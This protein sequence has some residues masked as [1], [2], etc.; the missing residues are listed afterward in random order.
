MKPRLHIHFSILDQWRYWFSKTTYIPQDGEYLMNHSR[1]GLVM[2]MRAALPHGGRVGVMV[3]NCHTVMNAIAQAGC[4]PV[5]LDINEQMQLSM[6]DSQQEVIKNLNAIIVTHLFGIHNDIEAIR[7]AFPQL[8]IIEDCA[9]AYGMSHS[10]M[11]GDFATFSIGQ[12][13][14]PSIGD[15]G[16]LWVNKAECNRKN[17]DIVRNIESLYAQLPTYSTIQEFKLF[18]RMV[19]MSW[20]HLPIVYT[21]LTKPILKRDKGPG[22]V[23]T[24]EPM[25]RMAK[26]VQRLYDW[27]KNRVPQEIEKQRLSAIQLQQEIDNLPLETHCLIGDNAFMLVVLCNDKQRLQVMIQERGI[28]SATH[29]K[30]CIAWAKQFGY[31]MGACPIAEK[32]TNQLLMIPTYT[33][34]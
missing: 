20:L 25:C 28:E 22:D 33:R 8:I 16:V 29:F 9:H 21:Y 6:S 15:G 31:P 30:Y 27:V 3:Y 18:A 13:K 7:V 32:M 2:A 10:D 1:S 24:I 11:K 34:Q 14:L 17:A 5:F 19:V 4:E 23:K 26:G 12:G